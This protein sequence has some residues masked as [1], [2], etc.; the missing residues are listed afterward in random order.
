MNENKRNIISSHQL[1]RRKRSKMQFSNNN[2]KLTQSYT[3]YDYPALCIPRS[4]VVM[5]PQQIEDKFNATGL[6]IVSKVVVKKKTYVLN[7][8]ERV[9]SE[10][11]T[12]TEVEYTN[13]YIYFKKWNLDNPRV[14]EYRNRLL[15]GNTIKIVFDTIPSPVFWRCSAGRF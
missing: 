11:K 3:E 1:D 12:V 5:T 13:I 14:C 4:V 9:M 7:E 6:G 15:K 10:N 8:W 2:R